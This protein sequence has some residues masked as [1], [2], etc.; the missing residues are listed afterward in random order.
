VAVVGLGAIG[1]GAVA[2]LAGRGHSVIGLDRF[3]TP[4][5]MGSSHGETRMIREAY[6]QGSMYVP[7]VQA[8]YAGWADLEARSGRP[9]LTITGGLMIG[10]PDSHVFG[11]CRRTARALDLSHE[12]LTASEVRDRFPAFR[13]ETGTRAIFEH[14][15]GFLDLDGC[16]EALLT[17]ASDGG[18]DLRF[19]ERVTRWSVQAGVAIVETPTAEV[20]AR[21]LVLAAGAWMG[22]LTPS[23]DLPLDVERTVQ[24]WFAPATAGAADL[25]DPARCPGWVW[26]YGPRTTW[27]GFPLIGSGIKV[28]MHV[29]D[30]RLADPETV[31][32]DVGEGETVAMRG[33]LGRF[34]P[35]A[36]GEEKG[37][38]VCMYTNTPDEHFIL[39]RHPNHP[40]VT[41]FAGGSGHGFKFARVIGE[42]LADL[43]TARDPAHDLT[44]FRA[45]RF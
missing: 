10:R 27:Y 42:I 2:A 45:T 7:M 23:L 8:A 41:L 13:L 1:S 16:L 20:R 33:V 11:G 35:D 31:R 29:E 40:E 22:S 36:N 43:A 4:H 34:M 39:D 26:E 37:A 32:R 5:S 14:R 18:A 9:L 6:Y 28:D 17:I 3:S 24:Y 38:S 30:G 12:E 21:R 19:G 44:P 25:F 15:A